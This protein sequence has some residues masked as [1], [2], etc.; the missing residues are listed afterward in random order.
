TS[1]GNVPMSEAP[2]WLQ[3]GLN[4]ARQN[5]QGDG[6]FNAPDLAVDLSVG[7][8]ACPTSHV[9]RAR[10][11]NLGSL[12][13]YM[14]VPIRFERTTGGTTTLVGTAMTTIPLLPGQSEVVTL[15]A[16]AL[17]DLQDYRVIVDEDGSPDGVVNECNE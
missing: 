6:V 9:L 4:N 13:V 3:P 17:T 1:A 5:V 16:P 11:T 12:G 7:L 14:G 10:V 2:N 8:D 15:N